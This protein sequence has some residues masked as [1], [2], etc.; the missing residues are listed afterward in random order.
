MIKLRARKTCVVIIVTGI[1]P[2]D[3]QWGGPE[4][5][6]AGGGDALALTRGALSSGWRC[7]D[8]VV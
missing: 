5:T 4:F 7:A 3:S 8:E 1:H 2:W 6:G